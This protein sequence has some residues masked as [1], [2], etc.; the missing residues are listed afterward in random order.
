MVGHLLEY[1]PAVNYMKEM[2][3][4][5]KVGKPLYLYFQRV[6]LGIVRQEENAWW[7]LAPHDISVACYL[8]DAEPASVSARAS[9]CCRPLGVKPYPSDWFQN[10]CWT[11][12]SLSP[13]LEKTSFT[14][15][16]FQYGMAL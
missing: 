16:S 2:I 7:S 1:H 11:L 9:A 8:F 13:C 5:A 3:A 15:L 14:L 12:A 4:K 6:N 10:T